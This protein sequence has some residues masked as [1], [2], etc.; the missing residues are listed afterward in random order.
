VSFIDRLVGTKFSWF[1]LKRT[2]YI[3]SANVECGSH[4]GLDLDDGGD[5][6]VALKH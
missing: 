1:W 6:Q 3:G 2:C 5:G 4:D